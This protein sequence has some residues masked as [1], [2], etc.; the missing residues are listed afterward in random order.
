MTDQAA[1]LR[2]QRKK[3]AERRRGIVFNNDGDDI[4]GY[5][6]DHITPKT[7]ENEDMAA[8]PEGLLKMR[9]RGVGLLPGAT[10]LRSVAGESRAR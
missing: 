5:S 9:T 8:T 1:E 3:M 6:D 4:G 10:A 2:A 7:K